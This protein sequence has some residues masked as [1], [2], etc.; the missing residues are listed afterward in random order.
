MWV[1]ERKGNWWSWLIGVLSSIAD[2]EKL[3]H[4]HGGTDLCGVSG[5][6]D[7]QAERAHVYKDID[8]CVVGR[9]WNYPH[10]PLGGNYGRIWERHGQG[11]FR[12]VGR[13]ELK[14]QFKDIVS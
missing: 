13:E 5:A 3:L 1:D 12:D 11:K 7:S 14:D 10:C 8:I 4:R 2:T 6:A 9:L